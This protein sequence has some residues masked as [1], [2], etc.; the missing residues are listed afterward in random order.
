MKKRN[1]KRL[2]LTRETL[3]KLADEQLH[4]ALGERTGACNTGPQ[5]CCST[6]NASFSCPPPPSA[7]DTTC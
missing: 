6:C 1:A 4:V 5:Q 2:T 7:G 3:Q